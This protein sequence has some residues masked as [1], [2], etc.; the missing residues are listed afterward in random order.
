MDYDTT[1]EINGVPQFHSLNR[2]QLCYEIQRFVRAGCDHFNTVSETARC[3]NGILETGED[4]E[5]LEVGNRRCD[6]CVECA[7][8]R[9]ATSFPSF[10]PP[11][12]HPSASPTTVHPSA[13]PTT[14]VPS[15]ALPSSHP[16]SYPT[17]HPSQPPEGLGFFGFLAIVF[18]C[19]A[20]IG[21]ISWFCVKS[22]TWCV[23]FCSGEFCT[24]CC[25]LLGYVCLGQICVDCFVATRERLARPTT[26]TNPTTTSTP[27]AAPAAQSTDPIP[28]TTIDSAAPETDGTGAAPDEVKIVVA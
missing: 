26:S 19:V 12:G 10:A 5:C 22:C 11:T 18:A 2:Y 16:T 15:Y 13:S 6:W 23:N 14:P 28:I 1:G 9:N 21:I 7:P 17:S 25:K 8:T 3:G 20:C 27:V 4:C 24:N